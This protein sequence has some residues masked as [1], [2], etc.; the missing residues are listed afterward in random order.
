MK[1]LGK[2]KRDS[3]PLMKKY[4]SLTDEIDALV[5]ELQT[6]P[7]KGTPIGRSCYKI[8]LAIKSKGT[9]KSG[10]ARVITY[11]YIHGNTVY[12][13]SIYDKS[14]RVTI[15]DSELAELLDSITDR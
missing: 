3:K 12:L 15:T 4:A 1:A 6:N 7:T 9:G 10:G 11:Y 5:E 13:L 8:R 2:F 14:E